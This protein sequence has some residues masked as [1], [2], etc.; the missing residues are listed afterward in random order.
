MLSR[1]EVDR[2]LFSNPKGCRLRHGF[3]VQKRFENLNRRKVMDAIE[4]KS[5]TSSGNPKQKGL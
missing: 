5:K 1:N 2:R 3:L 4:R